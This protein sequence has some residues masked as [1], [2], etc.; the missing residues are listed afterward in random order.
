M[1]FIKYTLTLWI[2]AAAIFSAACPAKKEA[3]RQAAEAAYRL[4]AATNDVIAKTNEALT[5]GTID[6]ATARKL[7]TLIE[8]IARAEVVFVGLVRTAD[9]IAGQVETLSGKPNKSDSEAAQLLSLKAELKAKTFDIKSFFDLR[10]LSPFLDV[11]TVAKLLTGGQA[12]LVALAIT[13]VK[14]ILQT[15]GKGL[16]SARVK[17]IA[18]VNAGFGVRISGRP[19]FA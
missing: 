11:L 14:L 7:G 6:A 3:I 9:A 4:P 15:I 2:L 13:S 5:N 19:V 16:N 12:Q 1:D 8:P 10:I 18:A 17:E